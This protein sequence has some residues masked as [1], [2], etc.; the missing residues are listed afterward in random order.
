MPDPRELTDV[1][2]DSAL[3][4]LSEPENGWRKLLPPDDLGSMV[5]AGSGQIGLQALVAALIFGPREWAKAVLLRYAKVCATRFMLSEPWSAIYGTAIVSCWAA[6]VTIARWIG[7][8]ELE[9]AFIRLLQSWAG[10][11][12]LM[13][14]RLVHPYDGMRPTERRWVGQW[15]VPTAGCRSWG[16]APLGIGLHDLWAVATER[17]KAPLP[18]SSAYGT[19]GAYDDWGWLARARYVCRGVLWEAA[20][21]YPQSMSLASLISTPP[22]WT[23]R[24]TFQLLGWADGSRLWVMGGDEPERLDEDDNGNTPGILLAGVL[25]GRLVWL[26]KW[27]DPLSGADHLRQTNTK[28]DVDGSPTEGWML[29]HSHF[30]E[31]RAPNGDGFLSTLLAYTAAPLLFHLVL[32]AG[33]T[34]WNVLSGPGSSPV[35]SPAPTPPAPG[36][37]L[38]LSMRRL[39]DEECAATESDLG[40]MIVS[41]NL[42]GARLKEI[43]PGATDGERKRW[44]IEP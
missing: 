34:E 24:E 27:P 14:A 16:V 6:V 11:L 20:D 13:E 35:P 5:D 28:A 3:H 4:R 19:P 30:G 40:S 29:W 39:S 15:I 25:G 21:F 22:R 7:D 36:Q 23:A 42:P 32:P 17:A 10:T 31:R 9:R 43:W 8:T 37:V 44:V 18:G 12:R 41:A 38:R 2:I 33:G 26:P 1:A